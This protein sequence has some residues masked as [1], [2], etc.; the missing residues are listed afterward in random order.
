VDEGGE[1]LHG[2]AADAGHVL[3]ASALLEGVDPLGA[4]LAAH[5]LRI[6]ET[7]VVDSAEARS[8]LIGDPSLPVDESEATM[9]LLRRARHRG[10]DCAYFD[11][12]VTMSDELDDGVT[13]ASSLRGEAIIEVKTT[14]AHDITLEGE[15]E[16]RMVERSGDSEL[17][18]EGRGS[19][20][21]RRTGAYEIAR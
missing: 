20:R 1:A 2:E 9:T 3:G 12:V 16:L 11:V 19:I 7:L 21:F 8:V 14:W 5:P 10:H 6:G 15:L 18:G 4:F 13:L 17:V